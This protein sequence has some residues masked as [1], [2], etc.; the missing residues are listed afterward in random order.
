MMATEDRRLINPVPTAIGQ[1][2]C[3][4]LLASAGPPLDLSEDAGGQ[5]LTAVERGPL[6]VSSDA[7]DDSHV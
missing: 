7:T 2:N 6:D 3:D 1:G 5:K 4:V